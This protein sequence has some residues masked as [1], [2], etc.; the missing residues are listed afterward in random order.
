MLTVLAW[1]PI[2][3]GGAT[4]STCPR[5]CSV[6]GCG[7]ASTGYSSVLVSDTSDISVSHG[8][9]N[10]VSGAICSSSGSTGSGAS[11][12]SGS[13]NSVC[14]GEG[15]EGG[16]GGRLSAGVGSGSTGTSI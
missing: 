4:S 3:A 10:A 8:G 1:V 12:G 5:F 11:P 6:S 16:C 13:A 15:G 2:G 7:A 9:S 14:G